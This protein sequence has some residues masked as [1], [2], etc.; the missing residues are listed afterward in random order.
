[1]YANISASKSVS[2][3][4]VWYRTR[5]FRAL[6]TITNDPYTDEIFT[7]LMH[8]TW[9]PRGSTGWCSRIKSE[10]ELTLFLHPALALVPRVSESSW[11]RC[12]RSSVTEA[13]LCRI[14]RAALIS[15]TLILLHQDTIASQDFF[16][17]TKWRSWQQWW[18]GG[19]GGLGGGNWPG[20]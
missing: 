5:R 18:G 4:A 13:F 7:H 2:S 1:M 9:N 3:F 20:S 15:V 16:L 19:E 8:L 12:R 17:L 6:I 10:S 11:P 14:T